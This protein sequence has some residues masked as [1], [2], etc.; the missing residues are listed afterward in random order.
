[1]ESPL[2]H[3]DLLTVH[4]PERVG[5]PDAD[6]IMTMAYRDSLSPQR[7]ERPRVRGETA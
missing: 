4:E 6:E 3:S 2:S 5:A 7:G 1:M